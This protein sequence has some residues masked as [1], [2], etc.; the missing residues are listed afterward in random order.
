MSHQSIGTTQQPDPIPPDD[1]R[2]RAVIVQADDD[3]LP[4]LSVVGDNYTVLLTGDDTAQRYTLIATTSRR[5]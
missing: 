1:P 4:H 3:Q 5:C 2:R